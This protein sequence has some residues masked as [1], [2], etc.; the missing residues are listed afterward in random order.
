MAKS[1]L[2]ADDEMSF[3]FAASLSLRQEGYEVFEAVNGVDAFV[4]IMERHEQAKPYDVIMLDIQMPGM[5]GTEVFDAIKNQGVTTPVVFVSGYADDKSIS[6]LGLKV[7]SSLLHK[8]FESEQMLNMVELMMSLNNV[9][10]KNRQ[11]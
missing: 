4:K 10:T 6:S 5:T 9:T 7:H 1:I 2:I 11:D 8:P 3:R